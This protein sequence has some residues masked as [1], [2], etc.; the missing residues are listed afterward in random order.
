MNTNK[1]ETLGSLIKVDSV[2][3][4]EYNIVPNT[5][6]LETIEPYPLYHGNVPLGAKPNLIFLITSEEY[7]VEHIIRTANRIQQYFPFKIDATPA[8]VKIY[9]DTYKGIRLRGLLN[10]E[11]I[12]QI[13]NSLLTEGLKFA[14]MK[15]I[16]GPALIHLK[17]SYLL[18]EVVDGIYKDN[19][20]PMM[21]YFSI[22]V[23]IEWNLLNLFTNNIKNNIENPNFDVAFGWI[24]VNGITDVIRIYTSELSIEAVKEL[25]NRYHDE[26][27]KYYKI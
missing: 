4:V 5:F 23:K 7:T 27:R 11:Q 16:Q 9:N 17:K 3:T 19:V 21:W 18:T 8:I 10:F 14:K 15:K 2:V 22:P 25:Q 6:V 12:K 20:E 26:F 1:I 24:F 13:Q